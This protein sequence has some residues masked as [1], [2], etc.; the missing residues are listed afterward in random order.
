MDKSDKK[1]NKTVNMSCRIGT[2]EYELLQK[3]SEDIGS[4]L[5]SVV[6]SIIKRY[7]AWEKNT[8][9]IGF[10]PLSRRTV[11][12]IFE[13]LDDKTIEK[14]AKE[15][16]QTIPKELTL[17]MFN[18]LDLHSVISM[19]EVMSARFGTL[20]HDIAGTI[21]KMILFHGV[22]EKFSYYLAEV[23]R[24]MS[25]DLNIKLT[26]TQVEKNLVSIEI[27]EISNMD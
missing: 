15:I 13:N 9:E 10:I 21:H 16:G 18:N 22:N 2:T 1:S 23:F 6:N 25:Q 3:Y 8:N 27:S 12:R 7:L 24:A 20:R 19:M 17:L 14:I 11:A 5:N 4:S 26:V